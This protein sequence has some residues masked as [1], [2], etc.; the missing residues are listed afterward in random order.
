MDQ[1][2]TAMPSTEHNRTFNPRPCRPFPVAARHLTVRL[3]AG[4]L[5][6]IALAAAACSRDYETVQIDEIPPKELGPALKVAVLFHRSV[7]GIEYNP[8]GH[9]EAKS[10]T[11]TDP[12]AHRR[13]IEQLQVLAHRKGANAVFG[14]TCNRARSTLGMHCRHGIVCTGS[15][16]ALAKLPERLPEGESKVIATGS[17]F[18]VNKNG[19]MVTNNHVVE[20]CSSLTV[21]HNNRSKPATVN[22]RDTTADLAVLDTGSPVETFATFRSSP[23]IRL[24]EDVLAVGYPL[25]GFL[26]DQANATTGTIS[27]LAGLGGNS[28][29]LQITAPIQPGNSGGPLFDRSGNVIGVI[30]SAVNQLYVAGKTGRLPENINFAI[31]KSVVFGFLDSERVL[32]ESAASIHE[33]SNADIAEQATKF[34]A[35]IECRSGEPSIFESD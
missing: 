30:V 16:V 29:E 11:G 24:S 34:T 3:R 14:T 19:A 27:S 17:G 1:P 10:C 7:K 31:K 2:V 20:N 18:Y 6:G 8:L 32:Y 25:H 15:A 35:L 12:A 22:G 26:A 28:Q 4:L 21:V 13:A 5:L 33:L 9:V 23:K